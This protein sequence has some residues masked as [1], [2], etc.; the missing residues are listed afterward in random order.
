MSRL[1]PLVFRSWMLPAGRVPCY[2]ILCLLL[3]E[4]TPQTRKVA[5]GCLLG[6]SSTAEEKDHHQPRELHPGSA[7]SLSSLGNPQ[8][9]S[10]YVYVNP[11]AVENSRDYGAVPT[12][13]WFA[14]LESAKGQRVKRDPK[15]LTSADYRVRYDYLLS[16]KEIEMNFPF[17]LRKRIILTTD[18]TARFILQCRKHS[19]NM[20]SWYIAQ[21]AHLFTEDHI[22][23][24][25]DLFVV[26]HKGER[27]DLSEDDLTF[28]RKLA[29][30][31]AVD[32]YTTTSL[33]APP[34]PPPITFAQLTTSVSPKPNSWSAHDL[35]VNGGILLGVIVGTLSIVT[36]IVF[37][38]YF[39][40]RRPTL[41][42]ISYTPISWTNTNR[43]AV[44]MR[45]GRNESDIPQARNMGGD[46]P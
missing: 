38:C 4:V 13:A 17:D 12:E 39:W 21:S 15:R 5:M 1:T 6:G 18:F 2:F 27:R 30:D 8:N 11:Y 42:D 25:F 43:D 16:E 20:R 34:S 32:Q 14:G 23:G 46:I 31:V 7:V 26:N 19:G 29:K 45:T 33:P 40:K 44:F 41:G 3:L 10:T 9:T 24:Y 28:L 37:L 22:V 36:L 35:F